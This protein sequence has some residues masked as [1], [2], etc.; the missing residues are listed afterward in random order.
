MMCGRQTWLRA[1]VRRLSAAIN[2]YITGQRA[3]ADESTAAASRFQV[4]K[5]ASC[6]LLTA[7][8]LELREQIYSLVF[9]IDTFSTLHLISL[10]KSLGHIQCPEKP[11][12]HHHP[13]GPCATTVR[14][15]SYLFPKVKR[16]ETSLPFPTDALELLQTCRRAYRDV[17]T[18]LS[19][20]VVRD[21]NSLSTIPLALLQTCRLAYCDVITFLYSRP[22]FSFSHPETLNWF[23]RTIPPQRLSVITKLHISLNEAAI[24]WQ[25]PADQKA[26]FRKKNLRRRR[27]RNDGDLLCYWDPAWRTILTDMTGLKHVTVSL[28]GSKYDDAAYAEPVL[29]PLLELR[30]LTKFQ[31][32]LEGASEAWVD[33]ERL[34]SL[35][36]KSE[37]LRVVMERAT[38]EAGRDKRKAAGKG[39]RKAGDLDW[40][41]VLKK[42]KRR[43]RDAY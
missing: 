1:P 37:T 23:A 7:L 13:S 30:G 21:E 6:M 9:D 12:Y 31:V 22:T 28:V 15:A 39:K 34:A 36:E 20:K 2:P 43:R 33:E 27:A 14:S 42:K 41:L 19:P 4:G 32:R 18:Y 38:S 16:N 25:T 26:P 24:D 11:G 5:Q 29:K 35:K 17:S 40:E 8:S 3:R 10:T